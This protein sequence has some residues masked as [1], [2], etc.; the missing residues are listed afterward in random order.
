VGSLI[1]YS[2]EVDTYTS[3]QNKMQFKYAGMLAFLYITFHT[4]FASD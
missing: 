3:K 1:D 4:Y 2:Y